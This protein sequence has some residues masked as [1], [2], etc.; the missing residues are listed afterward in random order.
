MSNLNLMRLR[1]N[2]ALLMRFARDTH[3]LNA[4]DEGH[5]YALHA[6]LTGMF[7]EHAPKPFRFFE[8]KSE[9][10]GYTSATAEALLSHASAFAP[11][12]AF[13]AF[14][15]DSLAT[16]P[17]PQ[18]WHQG[19]RLRV[20]VLTCPVSRSDTG[21]KDVYLRAL[22]RLG[23][24]APPRA[25]VYT[26]WFRRQWGDT[27]TFDHLTLTG[28]SRGLLLRRNRIAGQRK[29][30]ILE[31]PQVS[32]SATVRIADGNGF[33]EKLMRGVGRHRTF[34]F[35]MILLRPAT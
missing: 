31:R 20:D 28:F 12:H 24:A 9:L 15:P 30:C 34:G 5:G 11:P 33:E 13:A 18:S 23:D 17:M 27:V 19:Q 16:K 25:D 26:D 1:L 22:D 32:F 14:I 6:W 29:P 4:P 35:G 2:G 10:L 3:G 8:H 21:E 7:G